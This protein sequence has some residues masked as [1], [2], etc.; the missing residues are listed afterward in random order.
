MIDFLETVLAGFGRFV[1]VSGIEYIA[2]KTA[3]Q[4]KTPLNIVVAKKS[5]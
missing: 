3:C 5:L 1:P 4:H 2:A